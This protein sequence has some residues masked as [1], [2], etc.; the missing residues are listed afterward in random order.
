MAKFT[1][2]AATPPPPGF[3]SLTPAAASGKAVKTAKTGHP[4]IHAPVGCTK[5]VVNPEDGTIQR[6]PQYRAAVC[7]EAPTGR[8]IVYAAWEELGFSSPIFELLMPEHLD[9]L[10]THNLTELLNCLQFH[11]FHGWESVQDKYLLCAQHLRRFM[12]VVL[13]DTEEGARAPAYALFLEILRYET[14][15]HPE[16]VRD[17]AKKKGKSAAEMADLG[18]GIAIS[19]AAS[20][21]SA[22][23]D[24]AEKGGEMRCCPLLEHSS[25]DSS[26]GSGGGG[27]GAG[28]KKKGEKKKEGWG[29]VSLPQYEG[30]KAEII[31]TFM[32]RLLA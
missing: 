19:V 2:A 10:L 1:Q 26:G 30:K 11:T 18:I 23:E 4:K 16:F 12:E 28:A 8:T 29:P 13:R 14:L 5:L 15:K 7:E 25:V 17:F 3:E 6:V 9:Y 32:M 24:S 31:R 21:T 20:D 22:E 27:S